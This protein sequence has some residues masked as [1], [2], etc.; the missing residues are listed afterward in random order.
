[1]KSQAKKILEKL[2]KI[3]E[4]KDTF[5]DLPD[6][7]K[8]ASIEVVARYKNQPDKDWSYVIKSDKDNLYYGGTL[9]TN[10][11]F[12]DEKI[13]D[14]NGEEHFEYTVGYEGKGDG[15]R[16]VNGVL[17]KATKNFKFPVVQFYK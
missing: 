13:I 14:Q 12:H 17:K 16:T 5:S 8:K 10:S 9:S 7:F 2:Q 4:S 15:M 1:M 3:K 11:D 6:Y